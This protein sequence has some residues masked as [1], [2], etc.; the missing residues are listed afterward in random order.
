M[1]STHGS[2]GERAQFTLIAQRLYQEMYD[3]DGNDDW[4]AW[5]GE[6]LLVISGTGVTI[7]EDLFEGSEL[8]EG[9]CF[10]RHS[11]SGIA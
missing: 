7:G 10:T 9:C 5:A 2:L 4:R 8:D 11:W 6:Q 1:S 3:E